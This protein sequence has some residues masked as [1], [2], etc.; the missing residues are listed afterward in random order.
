M[1]LYLDYID[2]GLTFNFRLGDL[3]LLFREVHFS[4]FTVNSAPS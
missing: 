3:V 2:E 4:S 1:L